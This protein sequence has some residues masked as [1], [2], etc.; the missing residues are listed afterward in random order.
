MLVFNLYDGKQIGKKIFIFEIPFFSYF[1]LV[2]WYF[3]S[4]IRISMSL[5]S[6]LLKEEKM[7]ALSPEIKF[8]NSNVTRNSMDRYFLFENNWRKAVFETQKL[9][10][11]NINFILI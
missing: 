3:V 7:P 8:E 2:F 11:G 9:K 10:N 5:S 6:A 4:Q 1:F